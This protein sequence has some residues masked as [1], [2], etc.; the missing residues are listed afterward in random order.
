[1]PAD[2]QVHVTPSYIL[3][4]TQWTDGP[5]T[6]DA[7]SRT[8]T[9]HRSRDLSNQTVQ[10]LFPSVQDGYAVSVVVTAAPHGSENVTT[11]D[12]TVRLPRLAMFKEFTADV[13]FNPTATAAPPRLPRTTVRVTVRVQP[14]DKH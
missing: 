13:S 4:S 3:R 1:M 12:G 11:A 10:F 5:L 9:Y 6:Y 14:H 8:L 2:V 7:P